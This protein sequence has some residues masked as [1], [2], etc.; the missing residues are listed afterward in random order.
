MWQLGRTLRVGRARRRARRAG[1]ADRRDRAR[2][3]ARAGAA[4]RVARPRA[5]RPVAGPARS[6]RARALVSALPEHAAR[7]AG[8]G[9][10]CSTR[11][12]GGL[13]RLA[14]GLGGVGLVFSRR[15]AVAGVRGAGCPTRR[16]R[17]A[18]VAHAP[19]A[20]DRP[21]AAARRAVPR[22]R[23]RRWS[24]AR[25]PTL[26]VLALA[27]GRVLAF[28]GLQQLFRLVLR[29]RPDAARATE[30]ERAGAFGSG[31]RRRA[32][33]MLAVAGVLAVAIAWLGR[34]ARARDLQG[35]AR[36]QRRPA[37]VRAAPRPGR[38]RGD[39]QRDVGGGP[40]GLDVRGAGAR[41][42]RPAGRRR[43]R[44][45]H[46][47]ARRRPGLGPDQDRDQRRARLHARDGEGG[48]QGG[49]RRPPS[50]S[51][52]AW[53]D[54]PRDRARSTSATAS[55]SWARSRSSPGCARCAT[56]LAANPR[57]VVHPGRRG[58]RRAPEEMAAA[59][60]DSGLAE[61]VF[62]GRAA[63]ALA[64]A[65]GDGGLGPA[66]RDVPRIG[67]AGRRLA[68]SGVRRDPGD[69]LPLP[70]SRRS[71]SCAPNRGGTGGLA[72]PDQP[73]DRDA[74]DAEAVERRDRQRLRFPARARAS[75]ARRSDRTL[76]N[77][78]AVD[79]YR[80]GDLFG[81]SST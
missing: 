7:A 66:R 43:A 19:A 64:D 25:R 49:P 22:R 52:S 16:G 68:A 81:S 10:A 50:A 33:V 59:F 38:V 39:A 31:T 27:G 51:A 24:C 4:P 2:A 55:A 47:R 78:I 45:S 13:R 34:P 75:N 62:R 37:P 76:P 9:R 44:V 63:P 53:S 71:F 30:I 74:A 57:E 32:V 18:G 14:L 73:L 70:A 40:A 21:A 60:A 23:R 79:F 5:R 61:L 67:Q 65:G 58:L 46:R 26:S 8:G 42:R 36:L 77:I 69:A 35:A 15:R 3:A 28:V 29:A 11:S 80:T 1:A 41:R 20:V 56:F 6:R 48:G 54:R 17:R 12:R 72:V